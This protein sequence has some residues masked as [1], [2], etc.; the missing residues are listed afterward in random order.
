M[1]IATPIGLISNPRGNGYT[2]INTAGTAA[3]FGPP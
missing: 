3:H 2:I 1:L